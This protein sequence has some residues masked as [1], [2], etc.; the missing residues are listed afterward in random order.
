MSY[1]IP[2][3]NRKN[4]LLSIEFRSVNME[5]GKYSLEIQTKNSQTF[6]SIQTGNTYIPKF[7][8]YD[9][10]NLENYI[11]NLTDPSLHIKLI[12][13]NQEALED[14]R[15]DLSDIVFLSKTDIKIEMKSYFIILFTFSNGYY[16]TKETY[17]S[18]IMVNNTF[19]NLPKINK[20]FTF[21]QYNEKAKQYD[22]FLN[23]S[24]YLNK[25]L[26]ERKNELSSK[27][28]SFNERLI[29]KSEL[30]ERVNILT[31]VRNEITLIEESIK[32]KG[33][34]ILQLK[35]LII[36]KKSDIN[37]AKT[38]L[39]NNTTKINIDES[40]YEKAYSSKNIIIDTDDAHNELKYNTNTGNA[41]LNIEN[42]ANANFMNCNI[43]ISNKEKEEIEK[44]KKKVD[45]FK[46]MMMA[47]KNKKI[48]ELAFY[49][50]NIICD[51]FYI[52]PTF[53]NDDTKAMHLFYERH[54]KEI[55]VMTGVIAQ[56]LNYLSFIFNIPLRYPLLLNGSK[57]YI[58]KNKRE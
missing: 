39:R 25:E 3:K 46:I 51:R 12:Y 41:I 22:F 32:N 29:D 45:K 37:I 19:E 11:Y 34:L 20:K 54:F 44:F 24:Y 47:L 2:I 31:S 1:M 16:I 18:L 49:F 14:F 9:D 55:S 7:S 50:F 30:K 53:S 52:I 8:L 42:Y 57:S 17:H 38:V 36:Q 33:T 58:V 48:A 21:F 27:L 6:K 28:N 35:K 5:Y 10:I 43:E 26:N 56:I 4:K 15:L 23:Q 13:N 40:I